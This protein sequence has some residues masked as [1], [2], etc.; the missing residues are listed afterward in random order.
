MYFSRR[1]MNTASHEAGIAADPLFAQPYQPLP[2]KAIK[3]LRE[4]IHGTVVVPGG[5]DYELGRQLFNPKFN[6]F[7]V[8]IV[9]CVSEHDIGLALKVA[10]DNG[11][12][13]AVR[14]GGHCTEGWSAS[15]GVLID[16]SKF[17]SVA[18]DSAGRW[19]IACSGANFQMINDALTPRGLHVPG[20]TCPDVCVGGYMQGGGYGF[21]ARVYG[22]NCD[23]V[24]EFRM[25]LADGKVVRANPTENEDLFW[26][27]RGGMGGNYGILLDVRYKLRK[28]TAV[29]AFSIGW[30]FDNAASLK[31]A[32][33]ALHTMQHDII[34]DP[35]LDN[36][37]FQLA[38]A[39]QGKTPK[40]S[41][42]CLMMKGMVV[43]T[44]E[45]GKRI[46]SLMKKMAGA[47][48][49]YSARGTYAALNEGLMTQPYEVPQLP[50]NAMPNE[51]KEARYIGKPVP[52]D[53]WKGLLE[54]FRTTPS[55]LTIYGVEMYGA[56][57]AS[58]PEHA[59]AFAHREADMDFFS[60]VFWFR[61]ED[62]A[63]MEDH[64]AGFTKLIAPYWTGGVYPNYPT[65]NIKDYRKAYWMD[66]F[67]KCLEV[68]Q[69]YDPTN[70]FS[71]SQ[72]LKPRGAP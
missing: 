33:R 10:R 43:G 51:S 21:T 45:E 14:S 46:Q 60:D 55:T 65:P 15:E 17:C 38:A 7:P 9:Y 2:P 36:F 57:I 42:P 50:I 23:N 49:Q 26:A 31:N 56:K 11:V 3:A 29:S 22:M 20:G 63:G 64:L 28:L 70:Y 61:D 66:N 53:G 34:R 27:V 69:K 35:K 8:V 54:H 40:T 37:G 16:L 67:K 30:W 25:M 5:N 32:A 71:F 13:V 6:K 48:L 18:V 44:A 72:S 12:T 62:R 19:A 1:R 24:E 47:D 4:G 39:Y 59:N 41:R 58:G 52:L 68:K